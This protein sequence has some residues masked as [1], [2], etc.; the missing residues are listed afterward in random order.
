MASE[1]A[2]LLRSMRG[3][4]REKGNPLEEPALRSQAV[5]GIDQVK[6]G[7]SLD[8]LRSRYDKLRSDELRP[9]YR[10]FKVPAGMDEVQTDAWFASIDASEDERERTESL[11]YRVP[12]AMSEAG[13]YFLGTN[14]NPEE[15]R[16]LQEEYGLDPVKGEPQFVK[17][18]RGSGVRQI[19]LD[20][21]DDPVGTVQKA[22]SAADEMAQKAILEDDPESARNLAD[23]ASLKDPTGTSDIASAIS[24]ARLAYREP[25]KRGR[26]LADTAISGVSGGIQVLASGVP[27]VGSLLSGA[28]LKAAMRGADV[29][30]DVSDA[31]RAARVI[32]D[33][34]FSLAADKSKSVFRVDSTN[35]DGQVRDVFVVTMPDGSSKAFQRST[36]TSGTGTAKGD[37]IPFEG[38]S[39]WD[40]VPEGASLA[41]T[42]VASLAAKTYWNKTG[43]QGTTKPPPGSV[44]DQAGKWIDK[45]I[46]S[47]GGND[48]VFGEARLV[49]VATGPVREAGRN[50]TLTAADKKVLG[51][52]NRFLYDLGA[53]D[54]SAD[55]L[56]VRGGS[57]RKQFGLDD[58]I[59]SGETGSPNVDRERDAVE[60]FVTFI[61]ETDESKSEF[62]RRKD[63]KEA[64]NNMFLQLSML[65]SE[66]KKFD[67]KSSTAENIN[68]KYESMLDDF[69]R[70]G[71]DLHDGAY[72]R[73]LR[74]MDYYYE[75][76]PN[77]LT[78]F[79]VTRAFDP[80]SRSGL[81]ME[82]DVEQRKA[83]EDAQLDRFANMIDR[84][85][86]IV[87]MVGATGSVNRLI[88]KKAVA[89]GH[90]VQSVQLKESDKMIL[91][92]DLN[93]VED[94][95]EDGLISYLLY[96]ELNGDVVLF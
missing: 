94:L 7:E 6:G 55:V 56:N 33:S 61:D 12:K 20:L 23:I 2:L 28:R 46:E 92:E 83:Q 31:A 74:G 62:E 70:L 69:S 32:D 88:Y 89:F 8:E 17:D 50:P 81:D 63:I 30:D 64:Y 91:Q 75:S 80:L 66:Y 93:N 16:R 4:S 3:F 27:L 78:F 13:R 5:S 35:A 1:D 15:E 79:D 19:G 65:E 76:S 40:R 73:F 25:E 29:A 26:H 84:G 60:P 57:R 67:P 68:S 43:Y 47:K 41:D 53:I 36:G 39:T 37:W 82:M 9:E 96:R 22:K 72:D 59:V 42:P 85:G 18:I 77:D 90:P 45:Y 11:S 87:R 21:M 58:P 38:Y 51:K 54:R 49:N 10:G 14:V 24:S 86:P 52:I 71:D 48:A 34:G 44:H 95:K